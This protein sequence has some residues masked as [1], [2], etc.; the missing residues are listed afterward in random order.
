MRKS[1]GAWV[2]G[3]GRSGAA[4]VLL[5][6]HA[7]L[8]L[9]LEVGRNIRAW[10]RSGCRKQK[11]LWPCPLM[12]GRL[13][14]SVEWYSSCL[15][16]PSVNPFGSTSPDKI[17]YQSC[18]LNVTSKVTKHKWHDNRSLQQKAIL[19]STKLVKRD[20]KIMSILFWGPHKPF[21]WCQ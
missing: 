1:I 13:A 12:R 9:W 15:V 6:H 3:Q 17:I 18:G 19:M 5:R 7:T 14:A 20:G 2:V 4:V 21:D 8:Y 16:D 11:L 10:H